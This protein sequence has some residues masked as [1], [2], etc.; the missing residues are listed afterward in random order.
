MSNRWQTQM[1]QV[2]PNRKQQKC[3][4][5]T[6]KLYLPFAMSLDSFE[7]AGDGIDVDGD[8][9]SAVGCVVSNGF[10]TWSAFSFGS[11]EFSIFI[12]SNSNVVC[13]FP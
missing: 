11:S 10:C 9:W 1:I 6:E 8:G 12:L 2:F 4:S 3:Y 7:R 5:T 13:R